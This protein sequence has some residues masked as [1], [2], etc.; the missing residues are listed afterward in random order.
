[1]SHRSINDDFNSFNLGKLCY[2]IIYFLAFHHIE[3]D[4]DKQ[5]FLRQNT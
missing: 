5:S 1:M 3:K 4:T 2:A